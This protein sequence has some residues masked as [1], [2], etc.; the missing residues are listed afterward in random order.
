MNDF[1]ATLLIIAL[2]SAA[3]FIKWS[4]RRSR[5]DD[6]GWVQKYVPLALAVIIATGIWF[7]RGFD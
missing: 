4:S 1:W 2:F 7:F 6:E 3:F 5:R